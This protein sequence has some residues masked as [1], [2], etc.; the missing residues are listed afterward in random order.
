MAPLNFACPGLRALF[1]REPYLLVLHDVLA[2]WSCCRLRRRKHVSKKNDEMCS[3]KNRGPDV[4][5][6]TVRKGNVSI[7]ARHA[8]EE[9]EG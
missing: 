5:Q 6:G 9:T 1:R 4:L 3:V 8:E 7:A 2:E